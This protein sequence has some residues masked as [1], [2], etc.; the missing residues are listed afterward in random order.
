MKAR[1]VF[2]REHSVS[3]DPDIFVIIGVKD[4][5]TGLPGLMALFDEAEVDRRIDLLRKTL[6]GRHPD[7][8]AELEEFHRKRREALAEIG[9]TIEATLPH[10]ARH[11]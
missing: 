11:D 8:L 4:K 2:T 10:E 5:K 9:D 6:G 3:P 7:I 1:P